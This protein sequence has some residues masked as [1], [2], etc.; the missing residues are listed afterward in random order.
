SVRHGDRWLPLGRQYSPWRSP[1]DFDLSDH[2]C[3]LPIP[4]V[5][6]GLPP[7]SAVRCGSMRDEL[8]L[9]PGRR[10][11]FRVGLPLLVGFG[12]YCVALAGAPALLNDGDTL[13]HIAIG[14]WI[15]THRAIP[16]HDPFTF[17]AQG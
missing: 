6:I 16:F 10:V 14:R 15:L 7:D 5:Q 12:V 1:I 17:T 11:S 8:G 4:H 9:A 2:H 13:S 3:R